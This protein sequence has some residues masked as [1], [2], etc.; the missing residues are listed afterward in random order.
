[1]VI[2]GLSNRYGIYNMVTGASIHHH[3]GRSLLNTAAKSGRVQ[4]VIN[5][6]QLGNP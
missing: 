3:D 6:L 5:L 2:L 1:M 4:T